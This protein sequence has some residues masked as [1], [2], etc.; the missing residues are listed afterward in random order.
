LIVI[1]QPRS[2]GLS[3]PTRVAIAAGKRLGNAVVRNRIKRRLR[4]AIRQVYPRLALGYDLIVIARAPILE[5]E[6]AQIVT[7]LDEVLRR[8][9]VWPVEVG[10]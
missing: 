8:A 9:K 3:S 10:S 5:A 1:V 6:F 4:E 2:D 7:A